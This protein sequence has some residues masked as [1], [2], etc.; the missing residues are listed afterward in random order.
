MTFGQALGQ[1]GD[2]GV[3][4]SHFAQ[5][6]KKGV[7]KIG[8]QLNLQGVKEIQR[9]ASPMLAMNSDSDNTPITSD[10]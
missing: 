7:S 1:I 8:P 2:L 5:S 3:N 10:F 6:S 4:V 9:D